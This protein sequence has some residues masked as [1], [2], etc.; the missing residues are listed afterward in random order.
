M[1][2]RREQQREE[3]RR[4]LLTVARAQFASYNYG[5]AVRLPAGLYY[6]RIPDDWS[7]ADHGRVLYLTPP[8]ACDSTAGY[9]LGPVAEE[10]PRIELFYAYN[11]VAAQYLDGER[12]ARTAVHSAPL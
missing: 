8:K 7:G 3:T 5:I 6:C 1:A 10:L 2:G 4:R 9:V 11:V 12:P